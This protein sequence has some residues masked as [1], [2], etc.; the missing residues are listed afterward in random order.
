[1]PAEGI[2]ARYGIFRVEAH[3]EHVSASR[4]A[5][6]PRF[7]GTSAL[8]KQGR[9]ESRVPEH[10]Q[11]VCKKMHTVDHEYAGKHPAFPAQWF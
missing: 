9:R 8:E 7:A 1:L 2:A 11:S 5:M 10:P 3:Q 6:R 4:G